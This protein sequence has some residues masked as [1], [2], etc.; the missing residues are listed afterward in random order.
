MKIGDKD[1]NQVW[2][3]FCGKFKFKPSVDKA[4]KPFEINTAFAVYDI[5][6]LDDIEG[7]DKLMTEMLCELTD[8]D[9]RIYALDW[10]H[11]S[12]L[13]RPHNTDSTRINYYPDGD[14]AFFLNANM[15]SGYLAHPWQMK[16][17]VFGKKWLEEFEKN[18][19]KLSSL[20]IVKEA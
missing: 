18:E 2:D 19:G 9:E 10:Q 14:Y 12:Y 3:K 13:Y 16:V 1:Y 6:A 15:E 8:K 4:V 7:F 11:D 20:G 17:W 5:S